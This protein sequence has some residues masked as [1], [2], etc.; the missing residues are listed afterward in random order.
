MF[1]CF[2]HPGATRPTAGVDSGSYPISVHLIKAP[3]TA[4]CIFVPEGQHDRS[5]ARS[6]WKS[7]PQMYRPVGH[8][9]IGRSQSQR[10]FSWK[11][12]PC[13]VGAHTCTNHTVPYGT[14]LWVGAV[15]GTSCLAT[16]SL[17]LRDKSHSPIEGPRI[18][19]ALIGLK[20]WA[21]SCSPCGA[22][23]RSQCCSS[24]RHSGQS[25]SWPA[26]PSRLLPISQSNR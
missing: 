22:I 8:G 20:P 5:Q 7:V 11:C 6:A 1:H 15:P 23:D 4:E 2:A 3:T 26:V 17:S 21:E 10:Y 12:A 25:Q 19:L 18:R 16:I 13:R 14:A 9:M 24:S